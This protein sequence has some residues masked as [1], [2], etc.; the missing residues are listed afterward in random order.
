M[1]N[2]RNIT[3]VT[4]ALGNLYV[5]YY[6][7]FRGI[8][9]LEPEFGSKLINELAVQNPDIKIELFDND[10]KF[11]SDQAGSYNDYI[12]TPEQDEDM[13]I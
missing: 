4:T 5:D 7:V 10:S 1:F 8:T 9:A 3:D 12:Q 6:V 2:S 13:Y 11:E